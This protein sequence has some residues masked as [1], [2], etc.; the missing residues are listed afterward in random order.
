LYRYATEAVLAKM[1]GMFTSVQEQLAETTSGMCRQFF[2]S[3]VPGCPDVFSVVFVPER[4]PAEVEITVGLY[5]LNPAD[6]ELE[7]AWSTLEPVM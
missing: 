7:S 3:R 6:P 5:K 1:D 4:Y 2:D